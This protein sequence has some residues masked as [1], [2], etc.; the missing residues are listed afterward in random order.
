MRKHIKSSESARRE[1]DMFDLSLDTLQSLESFFRFQ[2]YVVAAFGAGS[3]QHALSTISKA[4]EMLHLQLIIL[5]HP[6]SLPPLLSPDGL[7]T[8]QSLKPYQEHPNTNMAIPA[9]LHPISC[10]AQRLKPTKD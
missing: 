1:L 4:T 5:H 7:K 8:T 10:P 2:S 3:T 9:N 6:P